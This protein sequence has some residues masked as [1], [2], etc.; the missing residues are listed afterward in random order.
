MSI[1]FA[2]S[3]DRAESWKHVGGNAAPRCQSPEKQLVCRCEPRTILHWTNQV[4]ILFLCGGSK[5]AYN[6]HCGFYRERDSA[7]KTGENHPEYSS[8]IDTRTG[9]DD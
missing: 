9:E 7:H 6:I 1:L 4:L 2:T 8:Q 3:N 5:C